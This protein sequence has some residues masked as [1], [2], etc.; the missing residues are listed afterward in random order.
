VVVVLICQYF[1]FKNRIKWI[2]IAKISFISFLKRMVLA[3]MGK[4]PEGEYIW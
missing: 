3:P 2:I 1:S 4:D